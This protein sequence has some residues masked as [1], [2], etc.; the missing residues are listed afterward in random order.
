[1]ARAQ[2]NNVAIDQY[3]NAVTTTQV[4]VYEA[5][6]TTLSTLY[7]NAEGATL[8]SNPF[9][10]TS[11]DV[12][13]FAEPGVYDIRIEDTNSPASFTTK[14]IQWTSMP[15][16]EGVYYESLA[17]DSYGPGYGAFC[18]VGEGS[19]GTFNSLMSGNGIFVVPFNYILYDIGNNYNNSASTYYY[20][21][22]V[23][24]IYQ[25]SV[26][27]FVDVNGATTSSFIPF[28]MING[29]YSLGMDSLHVDQMTVSQG[30]GGGL[31]NQLAIKTFTRKLNAGDV[32]KPVA[33]RLSG[34]AT[35]QLN[36]WDGGEFS[37]HLIAR[38]SS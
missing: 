19:Y 16:V 22:P 28:M 34:K 13:F 31:G 17:K 30:S 2:Y 33:A 14:T 15:H 8:K 4:T 38:T 3:G 35:V 11:G 24:G 7:E 26:N 18:A 27:F 1:M 37:G 23:T 32:I 5:G 9:N 12:D 29:G 21:A 20:T 36:T 25:F 6:T 10:S